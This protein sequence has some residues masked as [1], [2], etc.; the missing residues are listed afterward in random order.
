MSPYA[1]CV[2]TR[3]LAARESAWPAQNTFP[4]ALPPGREVERNGAERSAA[5]CSMVEP[6]RFCCAYE[7]TCHMKIGHAVLHGGAKLDCHTG[8]LLGGKGP[9]GAPLA[10][11]CGWRT[12][13]AHP[14]TRRPWASRL[15]PGWRPLRL[16]SCRCWRCRVRLPERPYVMPWLTPQPR[17]GSN[18]RR[19]S[20]PAA[21]TQADAR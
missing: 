13:T 14:R 10:V 18:R 7:H 20:D 11:V 1:A 5:Q 12:G 16:G 15:R 3:I 6:T 17:W 19:A 9:C 21:W 8:M 2:H 4:V